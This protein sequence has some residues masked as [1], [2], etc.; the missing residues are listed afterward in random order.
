MLEESREP[1]LLRGPMANTAKSVTTVSSPFVYSNICCCMDI[2][3]FFRCFPELRFSFRDPT[4]TR[5]ASLNFQPQ[6]FSST[7]AWKNKFLNW[8]PCWTY[9]VCFTRQVKDLLR[10]KNY[11]VRTCMLSNAMDEGMIHNTYERWQQ[12]R[13]HFG[14]RCNNVYEG[15]GHLSFGNVQERKGFFRECFMERSVRPNSG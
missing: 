14:S 8:P 13:L 7:A 3:I 11:C 10:I 6:K 15:C 4:T 5:K 2:A 12:I 9:E 1:F